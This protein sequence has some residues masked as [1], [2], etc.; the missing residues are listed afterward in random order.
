MKQLS[1]GLLS[2]AGRLSRRDFLR[3]SAALSVLGLTAG[4]A[5]SRP[6]L[7]FYNWSDYIAPDTL[8]GFERE[9]G[10]QVNYDNFSSQ[11]ILIAKMRIGI[12]G[13]D[14]IVATDYKIPKLRRD[15]LVEP[16]NLDLIPNVK[17]L[18]PRF[19]NGPWDPGNHYSI[20][21][22]WGTTGIGYN[23]RLVTE[24][25]DSWN[26]LWNPRYAGRMSMLDEPRDA[27][28]VTLITLGYPASSTDPR[29]LHEAY[30]RLLLQRS[31][32][33]HYTND[34]YI[35]ELSS[36]DLWLCQGWSGDVAQAEEENSDVDYAIPR[37]GSLVWVDNLC[38]PRGAPHPETAHQFMNYIL[39][40][41]VGAR[42]S[43]AVRYA[44]PNQA[45]EPLLPDLVSDP[46]VYP[47]ARLLDEKKLVFYAD[48]G[49]EEMKWQEL[50]RQL[51]IAVG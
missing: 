13:Y 32:L 40:P 4:C 11:D 51:K 43:E 50:W 3:R 6:T 26:A 30:Q 27:I 28:G 21:W 33:K 8:P 44:S 18:Y 19:R 16:L 35:D 23:R 9:Y 42:L 7:N 29:Q 10:V 48:L 22:Q 25:V 36:N 24:K 12:F 14:L 38:I 45:A 15:G 41:D 5:P 2:S 20:P 47:P 31:L 1:I 37:E 34:T 17:N 49:A 39:R 46:H